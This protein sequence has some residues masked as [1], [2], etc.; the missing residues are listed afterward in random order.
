MKIS[1]ASDHAAFEMKEFLKE[2]LIESGYEVTDY[3]TNSDES[4]DYPDYAEKLGKSVASSETDYGVL[5]CGTGIG[6]SIAANK[7]KGIRAA[8]C[9]YPQMAELARQHNNA[10]VVVL[11]G[12]LMGKDICKWTVDK[13]LNTDFEGGRHQRRVDKITK[14]EE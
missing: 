1:I 8:L 6:A 3:G 7:I 9:L 14:L 5:L 12:R 13:F 4:V 10:N 11:G 2:Y